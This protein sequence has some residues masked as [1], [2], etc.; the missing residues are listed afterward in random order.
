MKSMRTTGFIHSLE[1]FGTVDG[2]GIRFVVFLQG[3]KLRCLY[4]QNPDTWIENSGSETTVDELSKKIVRYKPYFDSSNGGVTISGGE[5]LLQAQFVL[6]L[7]T[8]LKKEGIHTCLDTSGYSQTPIGH[9]LLDQLLAVTDLVMLDIKHINSEEHRKI[10]GQTNDEIL[11]FSH[12]LEK[13]QIP[14]WLRYVVVPGFTDDLADLKLFKAFASSLSNVE[15]VEFLP[16]HKIGEYKWQALNLPYL[17]TDV[18]PPAKGFIDFLHSD[19][20]NIF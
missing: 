19:S 16:F 9:E 10:T 2:P 5:P 13:K 6:E 11:E 12:Y 20:D 15:K 1:S 18:P 3:C 8:S 7:F 4:C 14:V 17:L